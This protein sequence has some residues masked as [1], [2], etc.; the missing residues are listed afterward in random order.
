MGTQHRVVGQAVRPIAKSAC[1]RGAAVA[2]LC[3]MS[4]A[5][6][7]GAVFFCDGCTPAEKRAVA[8][9]GPAGFTYVID[10]T[11]PELTLWSVEQDATT[12]A[13]TARD[14]PVDSVTYGRFCFLLRRP[15]TSAPCLP[16]AGTDEARVDATVD[17]SSLPS[18]ARE[19]PAPAA[20]PA[21]DPRRPSGE[22]DR[23]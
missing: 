12:R 19:D 5:A 2:L 20:E 4:S 23:R 6:M 3:A 21:N 13:R 11:T 17:V 14:V 1:V 22:Y 9:S 16:K 8:G 7:A 15:G 10:S 18:P